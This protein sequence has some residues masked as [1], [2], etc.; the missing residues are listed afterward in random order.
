ME[1]KG[2]KTCYHLLIIFRQPID[3]EKEGILS[4]CTSIGT[5]N[6]EV[7]MVNNN[8]RLYLASRH[9]KPN[10][11]KRRKRFVEKRYAD[12]HR[13]KIK[14]IVY[15]VYWYEIMIKIY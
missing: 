4:S 2:F 6:S 7:A 1:E 3:Y 15:N 14:H 10:Q 9:V 5:P 13:R 12:R 8:P 11:S